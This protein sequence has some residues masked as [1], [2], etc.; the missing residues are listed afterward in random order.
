M[1]NGRTAPEVIRVL[2]ADG[3]RIHTQLLAD[4]LRRDPLL[5]AFSPAPHSPDIVEAAVARHI[6][7]AV[8]SSRL[9]EEALG[10]LDA[11]RKI[12]GSCPKMRFVV[13][14]DSARRETILASFRAGATGL[15]SR[16][17]SL[18]SLSECVRKVHGGEIWASSEQ[19]TIALEAL[20]SSPAVRAVDA[21]GL[22][23]LSERELEVVSSLAEGLSNR[24]I[25]ARL[26]LSQHTI[27]NYLFRVFD[28]LGVSSRIELL[29]LTLSHTASSQQ[30]LQDVRGLEKGMSFA[31]CQRAAEHGMP[32]AQMALAKIYSEGRGVQ[33]DPLS[34]YMWYLIC[35]KN[36]LEMKDS[37][38]SEKR[39]M[40]E[41]LTTEEILQAQ[42]LA[43][44]YGKKPAQTTALNF[45]QRPPATV[46]A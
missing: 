35:E 33:R 41:L 17:A 45:A 4:A 24:E 40:A 27:K 23:L 11:I 39:K 36:I 29:F 12:R 16:D 8:I 34:A 32:R 44:D 21:N 38:G 42:K 13:L 3:T 9:D 10:G 20:A 6:D 22:N 43:S 1:R 37:I 46:K 18:E 28:K 26:G 2:V 30:P 14:L 19:I 5:E 7:V 25:A 31:S 15:F